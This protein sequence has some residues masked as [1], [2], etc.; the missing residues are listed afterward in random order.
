MTDDPFNIVI[1]DESDP[2][3]IEISL[4]HDE[5]ISNDDMGIYRC[6]LP[7][8]DGTNV[9]FHVGLYHRVYASMLYYWYRL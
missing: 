1:G 2:G 6:L 8:T 5:V 4:E 9:S 7:G 3:Y